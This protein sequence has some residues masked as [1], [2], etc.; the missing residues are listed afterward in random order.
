VLSAI[1]LETGRLAAKTQ[2]PLALKA[3]VAVMSQPE[4]LGEIEVTASVDIDMTGAR[5][6][7]A[8]S[9]FKLGF[10][11]RRAS[12]SQPWRAALTASRLSRPGRNLQ[13][14]ASRSQSLQP[15][16]DAPQADAWTFAASAEEITF[17]GQNRR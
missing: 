3:Q 13:R 7:L 15:D 1:N 14:R 4:V 9:D 16:G 10:T 6:V 11:G 5:P 2:L 17:D 8:A 12:L